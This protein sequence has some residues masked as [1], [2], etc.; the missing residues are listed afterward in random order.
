[1]CRLQ[2]Q[3]CRRENIFDMGFMDPTIINEKLLRDSPK[4]TLDNIYAL[5]DKQHYK[6]FILLPYNFKWAFTV[7]Q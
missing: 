3:R 5:L 7:F 1:M 4:E 6:N 2:I